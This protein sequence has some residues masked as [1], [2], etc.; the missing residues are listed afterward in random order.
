[1]S[2]LDKITDKDWDKRVKVVAEKE[3]IKEYNVLL[4]HFAGIALGGLLANA[5]N[6]TLNSAY[7]GGDVSVSE[8]A[9]ETAEF[10]MKTRERY[11]KK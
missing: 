11:I 10:M 1:M 2:L 5:H 3:A 4:D 7:G 6:F 9:Y 8:A